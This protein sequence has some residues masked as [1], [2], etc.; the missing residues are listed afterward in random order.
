M[1]ITN[2]EPIHDREDCG[3]E[4]ATL[5]LNFDN[6]QR[7]FRA[8]S[9]SASYFAFVRDILIVSRRLCISKNFVTSGFH[10]PL[11][12]RHIYGKPLIR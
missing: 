8:P 11:S 1:R 4:V 7:I 10:H 5:S 3:T 12:R 6:A 9:R 2:V